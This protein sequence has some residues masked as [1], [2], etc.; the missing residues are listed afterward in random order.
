MEGLATIYADLTTFVFSA[1]AHD[2]GERSL[3]L[4]KVEDTAARAISKLPLGV[5]L[6][7]RHVTLFVALVTFFAPRVT[8]P[9]TPRLD[10]LRMR[11]RNRGLEV[12]S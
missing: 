10:N 11:P 1:H 4:A 2:C 6:L 12:P 5:T 3:P 8:L 9:V 7:P